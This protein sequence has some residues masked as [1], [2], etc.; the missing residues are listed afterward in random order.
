M[1]K[2]REAKDLKGLKLFFETNKNGKVISHW[3]G[4]KGKGYWPVSK[5]FAN[6]ILD[7][8]NSNKDSN[9]G[10]EKQI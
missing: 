9:D 2:I 7:H 6:F 5:D 4:I 8:L 10:K 1:N 3:V